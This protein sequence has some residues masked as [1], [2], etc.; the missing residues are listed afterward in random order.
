MNSHAGR[1]S[2]SVESTQCG[3]LCGTP[4]PDLSLT[5][6]VTLDRSLNAYVTQFAPLRHGYDSSLYLTG[7]L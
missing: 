3:D 6:H 2:F 5:S 1:C 4:N 7:S